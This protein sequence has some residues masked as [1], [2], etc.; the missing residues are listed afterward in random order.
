MSAYNSIIVRLLS[1]HPKRIDLSLDR[2]WRILDRLGHPERGVPPVVHVAGTNG[3]GSAIAFMRAILEG[4]GLS[5]HVY[6]S[7]HLVRFNERFRLG[8]PGG[9]RLV[10]DDALAAALSECERANAGEPITVFEIETAAAFL[11]FSRNPADV[12]LL[13]VGLGGRLDATNV[14]EKPIACAITSISMDHL[15]FL[16]DTLEK[17]AAEKAAILKRDVPAA[18]APQDGVV[19]TVIEKQARR[20]RAPLRVAGEHWNVHEER[21]RLVYQDD[22]GL[23]DLPLPKLSGRH[24]LVNAGV[25]MATL[26]ASG[27]ALPLSA[28]EIG[29]AKAEWPARLQLLT[30]GSLKSLAPPGSEVWLDGAHNAEG[31]RAVAAALADLEERVPRPLVLIAGMLTTKDSVSFLNNFTG[32]ARR[33]IAVPIPRQDKSIPADVLASAA[34]NIGLPSESCDSLQSALIATGRLGLESSPRIL[35]TGSLYLAGEALA[36]NGTPP[37]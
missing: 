24:Q 7:P 13:E 6:T 29:I 3:K 5:V 14:I 22:D 1:L 33:F 16:G 25:A 10:S 9:G 18:V 28:F 19:L 36:Q 26:R 35:I 15:E 4:A 20:V 27:L 17:I 37:E 21:G 12:L 11:L 8:A 31:G 32:L 34:R 23:L 2:M 30:Q